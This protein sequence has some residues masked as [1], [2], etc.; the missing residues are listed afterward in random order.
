ME[1]G[2][3][4]VRRLKRFV[5]GSAGACV[6]VTVVC[7]G[8]AWRSLGMFL[9]KALKHRDEEEDVQVYA[10]TLSV[11]GWDHFFVKMSVKIV[12]SERVLSRYQRWVP[13]RGD[14]I[15]ELSLILMLSN[16]VS[17]FKTRETMTHEV[18]LALATVFLLSLLF[19]FGGGNSWNAVVWSRSFPLC[20][21][22]RLM[23][24]IAHRSLLSTT[25]QEA[26]IEKFLWRKSRFS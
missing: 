23:V 3:R 2:S 15:A 22:D 19:V 24:L 7:P 20:A 21:A 26:L 1:I 10:K 16:S 25:R 12:I 14:P 18:C 8:D 17:L 13:L 11:D 4:S 5:G 6:A 9:Y